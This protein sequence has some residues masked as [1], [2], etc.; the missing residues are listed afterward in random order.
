MFSSGQHLSACICRLSLRL[1]ERL[2][3]LKRGDA[4]S[5]CVCFH[6]FN[7]QGTITVKMKRVTV[8]YR[9]IRIAV[10]TDGNNLFETR[11]FEEIIEI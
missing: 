6:Y 10:L 3:F 4:L 11:A 7:G 8:H 2:F 9:I 1:R 5:V